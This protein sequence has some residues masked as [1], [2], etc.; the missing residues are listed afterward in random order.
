MID[1]KSISKRRYI[2]VEIYGKNIRELKLNYLPQ[3]DL[4]SDAESLGSM[5]DFLDDS[6]SE[7]STPSESSSSESDDDVKVLDNDS[8]SNAGS[9]E[10]SK[11]NEKPAS[12][13]GPSGT[14]ASGRRTRKNGILEGWYKF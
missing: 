7:Q 10:S 11:T 5:K 9:V 4:D 14:K 6:D 8:D 12:S 2:L 1:T 13:E 3:R